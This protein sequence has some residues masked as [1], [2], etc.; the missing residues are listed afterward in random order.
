MSKLRETIKVI[1]N[2]DES[3]KVINE[4]NC[5]LTQ[6]ALTNLALSHILAILCDIAQSLAVI[7]D[8]EN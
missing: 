1:R 6:D 5:P 7:A 8:K 4:L 2:V 3:M